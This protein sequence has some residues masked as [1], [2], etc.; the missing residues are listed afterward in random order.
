MSRSSRPSPQ[1]RHEIEQLQDAFGE[2]AVGL[3]PS[4]VPLAAIERAGRARRRR[5]AAGMVIG[6]GLLFVPLAAVT[7]G[8]VLPE[9]ASPGRSE[10][11]AHPAPPDTAGTAGAVRVVAPGERVRAAA[12]V[13]LWLTAE[14]KHWSTPE[15]DHQFRSVVDGNVGHGRATVSLMTEPVGDRCFLSGSYGGSV[16][17]GRVV[18]DTG[19]GEVTA[20]VVRLAGAPD[21]GAWYADVPLAENLRVNGVTLYDRAG[22]E[23]ASLT[24]SRP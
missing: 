10:V 11:A 19:D 12:G 16:D 14:G 23:V 7:V 3:T 9:H 5:R 6:C 24:P 17:V 20:S 22:R 2:V 15:T 4:P 18:V 1:P 8:V 13:E 21:W